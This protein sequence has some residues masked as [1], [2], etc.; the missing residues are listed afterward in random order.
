MREA[1]AARGLRWAF[2]NPKRREAREEDARRERARVAFALRA[3]SEEGVRAGVLR[4]SSAL[5][6]V[7]H[8]II[9]HYV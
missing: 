3:A 5:W 7:H 4:V 8:D 6:M 9:H 1:Q 2:F